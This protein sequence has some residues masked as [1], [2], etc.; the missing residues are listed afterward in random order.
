MNVF[1][2][3]NEMLD[4][5]RI[6]QFQL[7][8]LQALAA[9]LKRNVRRYRD[10]LSEIRIAS[11]ADLARLP[12]T[13]PEDLIASFPYGM[14]AL[15]MREV[16][17]LHSIVGPAGKQL[18]VGHTRND[19]THWG[20]LVARQLVATGVNAHDVIQIYFSGGDFE[21]A[22]GFMRGAE[23][24]EA[25][26]APD[27]PFHIEY[28]L[29]TLINYRVTVLVTTPTN[30]FELAALM[31]RSGRAPQDL[32][33]RHIILT[34][35][36]SRDE[37][38]QLRTD[39]FAEVTCAFG[40]DEVLNPG[41]C[42]ECPQGNMHV[43]EDQ[44]LV[45]TRDGELVVTTLCREAMPLLRYATRIACDARQENCP[46]GRTGIVLQPK[47]RLDDRLLINET[48]LYRE[49]IES[50]L[51]GTA[52]ANH[53][54]TVETN[55]KSV[56]VVIDVTADLFRDTMRELLTLKE[57][58]IREFATRLGIP[59]EV[60]FRDHAQTKKVAP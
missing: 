29:A 45:E 33:L 53:A 23:T 34:R 54:F 6:E 11:L 55:D 56:T 4:R 15:P 48:P 12:V 8:R 26:V 57:A 30:A 32:L 1:D 40:V 46:C 60:R 9:R 17:R 59:A 20:R 3:R 28:Q 19:L 47:G 7:E 10:C 43:N 31:D 21:S 41:L 25:S 37:R 51:S 5:S 22:F 36:I 50:V 58:V 49:Q 18:V 2:S 14:F 16:M 27:D 35:P 42:V 52:A 44:F 38:E 13:E 24:I 39:L